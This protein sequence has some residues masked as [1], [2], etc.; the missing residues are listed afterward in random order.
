MGVRLIAQE[1]W[2]GDVLRAATI[3]AA[4]PEPILR[5]L[6]ET[7]E[8]WQF[9]KGEIVAE[10]LDPSR[11][12]WLMVSGSVSNFRGSPSGRYFLNNF[13]WPGDLL[14]VIP[15]LDNGVMPES[16]ETRTNALLLL[17]PRASMEV[18]M[19]DNSCL[20]SLAR[21]VAFRARMSFE[22][23]YLRTTDSPRCQIAKLLAYLPRRSS[24]AMS[25]GL[26]GT[27][28]WID[29]APVPVSQSELAAMLGLARQTVNRAMGEFQRD[30][31]VARDAEAIRVISF[32][33]LLAAMEEDEPLPPDW[34]AEIL[35]WDEIGKAEA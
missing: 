8:L 6:T 5:Q 27:S 28:G 3:F 34:R 15:T 16:Y 21:T 23:L 29:P 14:G 13:T 2:V 1:K 11:G 9:K 18:A 17:L 33:G 4:W 10:R 24:V 26:P 30:R 25:A 19:A 12:L 20:R 31:I 22:S 32:K 7:G 35:S